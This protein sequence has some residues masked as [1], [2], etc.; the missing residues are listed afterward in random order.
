MKAGKI[1]LTCTNGKKAVINH[2]EIDYGIINKD[3]GNNEICSNSKVEELS[4]KDN[5]EKCNDHLDKEW[6]DSYILK[7]CEGKNV[8]HLDDLTI[9]NLYNKA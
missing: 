4:K 9:D 5:L 2:K 8:C 6:L 7:Q 3:V 1:K